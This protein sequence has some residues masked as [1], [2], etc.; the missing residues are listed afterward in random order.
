MKIGIVGSGM[1]GASGAYA[2]ITQG[3]GREIVLVD[4]ES[5]RAEA[6]AED[7]NHAVP[8]TSPLTVRAGTYSELK[9]S[10]MVVISAGV[11]QKPGESRLDL[12]QRNAAVFAEIVPRIIEQA[13]S[14]V[15]V[16]ATN[17]LDIMTHLAVRYATQAGLPRHQVFGTGTML[18]TA[19]F[20]SLLGH[21]IGV[22]PQHVH[23]YVVGEHGDSE[24]LTWSMVTVGGMGLSDFCEH[25]GIAL[26]QVPCQDIS[27]RVQNAAY[28]I[29]QG[30][31]A[32]YYGIGAALAKIA[33][34]LLHD[35]RAIL[36]VS[37][38]TDQ[39]PGMA[40]TVTLSLPHLIGGQGVITT[41][42]PA[43]SKKEQGELQQSAAVIQR[44]VADLDA[45]DW[46]SRNL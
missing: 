31:G 18:D 26:E 14:A 11:S 41:I 44:A 9:G 3:I 22:D 37:A 10:R 30:K 7:L 16:V 24:V 6:E 2:M 25:Q 34:A 17:P 1:V 13:P 36:T 45:A 46:T 27:R 33:D 5:Q 29:I 15:L 12:L 20:R 4:K 40:E 35:Q 38:P 19:R 39:V 28:R 21:C 8:F 42:P 43:L 23:A 32:T